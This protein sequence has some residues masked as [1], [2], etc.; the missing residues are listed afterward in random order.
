MFYYIFIMYA[1]RYVITCAID[2]FYRLSIFIFLFHLRLTEY[3]RDWPVGLLS[4][5]RTF[6][7]ST[8]LPSNLMLPLFPLVKL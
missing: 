2:L 1:G 6:C 7:S 4:M 5:L 8:F 3:Y